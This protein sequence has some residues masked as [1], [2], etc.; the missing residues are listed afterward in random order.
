MSGNR[1]FE[2]RIHAAVKANFLMSPPLVVAFA[3]AGKIDIDLT[4]EPLGKDKNGKSV[5]LR[6]IW[7]SPQEIQQTISAGI[8]PA[9]FKKRYGHIMEDNPVWQEIVTATGTQYAWDAKSTY[10]QKPPYFE[11]F[12]HELPKRKELKN[13]HSLALFGD[14]VTTDH[15]SPAGAFSATSPAGKY[16]ISLGVQ[17][18]DFNSYGSRRGNHHVMMRGTFANV[19]IHN[20]MADGKEGGFTKLM[21]E[22]TLMPIFDACEVYA[23]RKMP[24]II[25]AGKDYGMGSSRDWAAKGTT[26]LGVRAVVARSFER[27]H[28]SNLVGMGVLPLE[29]Q[30]EDS[31]ESLGINGTETFSLIGLEKEI[32]PK[33]EL[34]LEIARNSK[35]DNVKVIA[36]IDTPIEVEYY[37]HGGI[38]P[39]VL[40]QLIAKK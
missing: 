8:Q 14:S 26:L 3:I 25:F 16:L 36:R 27:I 18:E 37:K 39:Y 10:I 11:G 12:S 31:W 13:M 4:K 17:P 5:F 20:M 29:F 23:Q 21:P 40:R 19:R 34:T 9:M 32:V 38:M 28:R 35:K 22:G 2:A 30:N 6:D 33:Q 7:P 24:L 1:N 15:I